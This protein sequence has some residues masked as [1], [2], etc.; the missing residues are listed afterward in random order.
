MLLHNVPFV[1]F[2]LCCFV[3]IVVYLKADGQYFVMKLRCIKLPARVSNYLL[4]VSNY[5]YGKVI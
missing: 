2:G 4:D 1:A 3:E 5:L